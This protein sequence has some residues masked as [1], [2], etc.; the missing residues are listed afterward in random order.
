MSRSSGGNRS[1]SQV[2]RWCAGVYSH[3]RSRQARLRQACSAPGWF[4]H[5]AR[6]AA[7]A[8][9]G[10]KQCS[11]AT[12]VFQQA[13]EARAPQVGGAQR[14]QPVSVLRDSKP[15]SAGSCR[16]HSLPAD[17]NRSSGCR[18]ISNSDDLLRA[19]HDHAVADV[20]ESPE[21]H[22][23][24]VIGFRQAHVGFRGKTPVA[25]TGTVFDHLSRAECR[26]HVTRLDAL[27][28]T[29]VD[30]HDLVQPTPL[31]CPDVAR[32]L[33]LGGTLSIALGKNALDNPC[34]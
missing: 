31:L 32:T 17:Y 25:E 14:N 16:V 33:S 18:S 21:H 5:A 1:S 11:S 30:G 3:S 29:T 34:R 13:D 28:G 23:Q 6:P 26:K 4:R 7:M 9:A 27:V 15:L 8:A 22:D 24:A 19:T 10:E 2:S 20:V 12:E